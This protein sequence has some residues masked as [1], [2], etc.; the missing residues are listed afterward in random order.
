MKNVYFILFLAAA[1]YYKDEEAEEATVPLGDITTEIPEESSSEVVIM[2]NYD[3]E[4]V[5]I[6]QSKYDAS[7]SVMNRYYSLS[8]SNNNLLKTNKE[9]KKSIADLESQI[10]SGLKELNKYRQKTAKELKQLADQMDEQVKKNQELSQEVENDEEEKKS[11]ELSS[12]LQVSQGNLS[13]PGDVIPPSTEDEDDDD[14][15]EKEESYQFLFV[16]G[17]LFMFLILE[18]VKYYS[19]KVFF[20]AFFRAFLGLIVGLALFCLIIAVLTIFV[21]KEVFEESDLYFEL[22][23]QGCFVFVLAW[24]LIGFWIVLACQSFSIIW[25]KLEDK[26][27]KGKADDST[28]DF[29][30]MRK[31]FIANPFLPVFTERVLRPDFN[32]SEYLKQSVAEILIQVFALSP[33]T[34]FF[35]VVE[36]FV[37]RAV[38]TASSS[39]KIYFLL[40]VNLT[41]LILAA[42]CLFKCKKI[43]GMLIPTEGQNLQIEY[44]YNSVIRIQMPRYLEGRIPGPASDAK[45]LSVFSLKLTCSYLFLGV[46]PNRHQLLFWLDSFGVRFMVS[47]LQ[48]CIITLSLWAS[49]MVLYFQSLFSY[50]YICIAVISISVI[51]SLGLILFLLP[52]WVKSLTISSS[53]EM[54]KRT[55]V[56]RK[57]IENTQSQR[58]RRNWRLQTQ[59]QSLWRDVLM[60]SQ[61]EKLPKLNIHL[62][63][64]IKEAFELGTVTWKMHY[65]KVK[66]LLTRIGVE[67]DNDQFRVFLKDCELDE[68][69]CVGYKSLIR[70]IK[71]LISNLSKKPGSVVTNVLKNY[72]E[73]DLLTIGEVSEYL[74]KNR[75][76]MR[77]EDIH[78]FL[79]DLHFNLN[80]KNLVVIDEIV[81]SS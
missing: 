21:L 6:D 31:I 29:G 38:L 61:D 40:G 71:R 30:I 66:D 41:V 22:V 15:D 57:V 25:E 9:L 19:D 67:M 14:G 44:D 52:L 10:A 76:F 43:C 5:N 32:F 58:M 51:S 34:F 33:L 73:K 20:S 79:V 3:T 69:D 47:L 11:Q 65:L 56:I 24:F 2:M 77:D 4:S 80:S 8:K 59:F 75:W 62:K 13:Q 42:I 27:C 1:V 28:K 45:I 54:M 55:E 46:Y 39:F 53:I 36:I 74:Q 72:F 63:T 16:I 70:G 50:D 12:F 26:L 68:E 60:D 17:L 18:T 81:F 7:H 78:E 48:L 37:W 49:V 23:Y 35:V 64:L